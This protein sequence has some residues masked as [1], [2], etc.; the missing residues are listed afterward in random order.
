MQADI[1]Y[2]H[3]SESSDLNFYSWEIRF[4]LYLGLCYE[5]P[6]FIWN[7]PQSEI[8]L[9]CISIEPYAFTGF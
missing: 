5:I 9:G 6:T 1:S 8:T 2:Y 4:L 7:A 3:L